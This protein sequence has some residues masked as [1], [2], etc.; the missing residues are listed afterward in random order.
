M[1]QKLKMFKQIFPGFKVNISSVNSNDYILHIAY[2]LRQNN[3]DV[4]K[5]KLNGLK[6]KNQETLDIWVLHSMSRPGDVINDLPSF[7]KYLGNSN[8]K[9]SQIKTWAKMVSNK[10]VIQLWNWKLSVSAKDAIDKGLK[11]KDIGDY[12]KDTEKELFLKK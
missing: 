5:S 3:K 7:K 1:L 11:G 4:V 12:I 2:M 9:S 6:Y 10:Y 8:L